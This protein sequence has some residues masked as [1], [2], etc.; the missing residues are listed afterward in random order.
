MSK[1]NRILVSMQDDL[2]KNESNEKFFDLVESGKIEEFEKQILTRLGYDDEEV[3]IMFC[4]DSFIQEYNKNDRGIDSP[5]D[6]LEYENGDEY[7]DE[8]GKWYIAGD[9]L[10]SFETLPKNAEYF[11][12]T[13]N[14]ELKRLMVH[15]TLHLNGYDHEE[16]IEQGIEPTDEMLK[17]Q[18]E[19]LK[20]FK[21]INLI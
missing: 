3:S 13:Q 19:V 14:E 6:I 7:E 2:E 20:E 17:L 10:I 12:V 21:D 11:S 15:G 4:T 9:M 1:K 16:H 5:T 8:E 18:E